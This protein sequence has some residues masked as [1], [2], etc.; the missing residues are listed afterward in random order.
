MH[1]LAIALKKKGNQLSGSDDEIFEPSKSR[2]K[3]YNILPEKPGWHPEK[4][5][6]NLDA[7]ILGMHARDDNPELK[8]ARQ[9]G[10]KIYSFPEFLYQQTKNKKRL[11][12]A[13]SHGKTT[14]TSM[15]MHVM[16]KQNMTFDYM[17]GARI[18]GFDTMVGLS[19]DSDI[20]VFEGDEYLSSPMDK[21]PKF[22]W[23]KPHAAVITGVAWDHV[24]V[25]PTEQNYIEQFRMFIK[26]IQEDGNLYVYSK[27]KILKA[28]ADSNPDIQVVKY[29]SA[30][31]ENKE[32][33]MIIKTRTGT[34]PMSVFGEHN[35]QN[36]EAARLLCVKSGIENRD[37][38]EALQDFKG[39]E[40]RLQLLSENQHTSVYLDFAHAPSKV[41]ATVKAVKDKYPDRKILACLELHTFSS[42]NQKFLPQYAG[43]L[44]DADQAFVYFNPEVVRHK[45]LPELDKSYIQKAF[46]SDIQVFTDS[47]KMIQYVPYATEKNSVVLIMTSGNL[48]GCDIRSLAEKITSTKSK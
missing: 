10:L 30:D 8:R 38:Y 2:L 45:N 29:D 20:A 42:L 47:D 14:I 1:N 15:V 31:Y 34:Y 5:T 39:A 7:I 6:K 18:Q 11:V 33:T 4:I 43:A 37:F 48:D 44:S 17:V 26:S 9:L 41:K 12:I 24:N 27:D 16:K 21:R 25:F 19:D 32:G 13:G 22:L 28:I 3:K 23:Y 46:H 35:A 36:I 40:R